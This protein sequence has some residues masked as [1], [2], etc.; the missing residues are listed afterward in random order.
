MRESGFVRGAND[1]SIRGAK[2]HHLTV[3][4][5]LRMAVVRMAD[6][7]VRPCLACTVPPCPRTSRFVPP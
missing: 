4:W 6:D 2:G 7:K 3:A 1:A 5:I